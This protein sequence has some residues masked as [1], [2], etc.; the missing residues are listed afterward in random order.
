MAESDRIK[1]LRIAL[2]VVRRRRRFRRALPGTSLCPRSGFSVFGQSFVNPPDPHQHLSCASTDWFWS[3]VVELP[4]PR[5]FFRTLQPPTVVG[6]WTPTTTRAGK[7]LTPGFPGFTSKCSVPQRES[8]I[9]T[10]V[11]SVA[12]T[13]TRR[14]RDGGERGEEG[15]SR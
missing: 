4:R 9:S 11:R 7:L 8:G 12:S 3:G 5:S 10:W 14:A 6:G 2:I 13:G 1:Y 15:Q